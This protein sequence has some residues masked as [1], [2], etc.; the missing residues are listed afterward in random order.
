MYFSNDP[1][2]DGFRFRDTEEAAKEEAKIALEE[3]NKEDTWN[4]E[5]TQICWG[6]VLGIATEVTGSRRKPTEYEKAYFDVIVDYELTKTQEAEKMD[7]L[8]EACKLAYRKH[9]LSDDDIGWDELDDKLLDTLCNVM[10]EKEFIKWGK[11]VSIDKNGET[12]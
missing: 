5:V 11:S 10:G 4:E 3:E 8:L 7:S 9:V 6:V 2:G 1:N 12:E